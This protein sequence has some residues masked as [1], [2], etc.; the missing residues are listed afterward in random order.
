MIPGTEKHVAMEF[1]DQQLVGNGVQSLVL[2]RHV[3]P[4][5][6]MVHD[7]LLDSFTGDPSACCM[8]TTMAVTRCSSVRSWAISSVNRFISALWS[9]S[10]REALPPRAAKSSRCGRQA[11]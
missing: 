9:G 1:P 2:V 11:L 5:L 4:P 8:L 3:R 10:L 6:C 7:P